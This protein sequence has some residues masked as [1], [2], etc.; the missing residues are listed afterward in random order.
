M[1]SKDYKL[2]FNEVQFCTGEVNPLAATGWIKNI[3]LSVTFS[4]TTVNVLVYDLPIN[5]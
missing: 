5:W 1:L 3:T 4:L 2:M